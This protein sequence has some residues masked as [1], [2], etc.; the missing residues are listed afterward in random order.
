MA[1]RAQKFVA[2][3]SVRGKRRYLGYFEMADEAAHALQQRS[4]E[5]IRRVRGA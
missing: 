1:G 5:A 3:I 4:N 2:T